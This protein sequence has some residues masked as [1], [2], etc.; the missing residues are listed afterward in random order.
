MGGGSHPQLPPSRF[1]A[2]YT[3]GPTAN[4]SGQS[5]GATPVTYPAVTPGV[6]TVSAVNPPT[7][8]SNALATV[9]LV[10]VLLFG[11]FVVPATIPMGLVARSQIRQRGQ[12]GAGVANAALVVSA[13]YALIA[14][15]A[16]VLWLMIP[17]D[18]A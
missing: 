17:A 7:Q 2:G 10:A 13:A 12:S 1:T 3:A 11:V 6:A 16:V 14:A 4:A 8:G 15:A 9:S 5:L 18:G